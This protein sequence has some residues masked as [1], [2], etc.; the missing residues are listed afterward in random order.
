MRLLLDRPWPVDS[1]TLLWQ[2]RR[3]SYSASARKLWR[4]PLSRAEAVCVCASGIL[5][6]VS[7]RQPMVARDAEWPPVF[8]QLAGDVAVR[9]S[10][11]HFD[12]PD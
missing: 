9:L 10:K 5:K 11:L 8:L 7:Q 12:V 6:L 4:A 2:L 1:A 3:K